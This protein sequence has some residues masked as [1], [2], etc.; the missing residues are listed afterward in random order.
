VVR[1]L[2]PLVTSEADVAEALDILDKAI[3]K[4]AAAQAYVAPPDQAG[5]GK[6]IVA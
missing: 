4:C 3:A 1:F 6:T 2:A 5:S